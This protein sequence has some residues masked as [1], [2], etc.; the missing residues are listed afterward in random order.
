MAGHCPVWSWISVSRLRSARFPKLENWPDKRRL[1][2]RAS[3]L[4]KYVSTALA[5][6]LT[7]GLAGACGVRQPATS[8]AAN[9]R[10]QMFFI[11]FVIKCLPVHTII[12]G[13]G[14]C[15][16]GPG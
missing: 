13:G 3:R 10:Q 14:E 15:A 16:G 12:S 1:S 6:A 7:L 8:T 5:L 4:W 2:G 9:K 11:M